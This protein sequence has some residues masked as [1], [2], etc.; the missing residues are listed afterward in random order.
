MGVSSAVEEENLTKENQGTCQTLY[1][2]EDDAAHS[3]WGK[4]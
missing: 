4:K 3:S 1:R 2:E